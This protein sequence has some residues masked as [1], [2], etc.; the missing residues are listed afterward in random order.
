MLLLSGSTGF[1]P[2]AVQGQLPPFLPLLRVCMAFAPGAMKFNIF[3]PAA[4]Y[5]LCHQTFK[6]LYR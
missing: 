3:T 2:A 6:Y 5:S 1:T 4:G